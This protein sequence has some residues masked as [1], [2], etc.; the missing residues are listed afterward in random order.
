[1]LVILL[2]PVIFIYSV[3]TIFYNLPV[4]HDETVNFHKEV[5]FDD[6][7]TT[8]DTYIY[9]AG[10][11]GVKSVCM[12]RSGAIVSS[13]VTTSPVSEIQVI[14]TEELSGPYIPPSDYAGGSTCRDGTHS[15]SVGRGTCS[16]HGGVAY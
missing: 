13:K 12:K 11:N 15:Y 14:G 1:M 4:C 16:W 5:R 6:S 7:L 8:D 10:T 9:Q 2:L 3:T